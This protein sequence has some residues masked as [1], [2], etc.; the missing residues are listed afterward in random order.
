MLQIAGDIDVGKDSGIVDL[1]IHDM[2]YIALQQTS[3]T[4]ISLQCQQFIAVMPGKPDRM[5]TPAIARWS[6][7]CSAG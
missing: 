5:A 2:R 4:I 7:E 6:S 3:G 1:D